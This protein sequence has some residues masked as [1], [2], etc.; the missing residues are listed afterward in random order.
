MSSALPPLDDE[1]RLP[2]RQDDAEVHPI[3]I[4]V[5]DDDVVDR[6]Q[7]RRLLGAASGFEVAAETALAAEAE[8]VADQVDLLILDH[9]LPDGDG[10]EVLARLRERGRGLPV[11]A[12]TGTRDDQ[13]AA[14]LIKAGADDYLAK[15]QLSG[16]RLCHSIRTT[17][18]A[19]RDR[20]AAERANLALADLAALAE[21]SDDLALPALVAAIAR[22]WDAQACA[23]LVED[24]EGRLL[25]RASTGAPGFAAMPIPPGIH[26]RHH[27]DRTA[28]ALRDGD[29]RARGLIAVIS[30]G[31]PH[32]N[33]LA[34]L[35]IAASRAVAV[36]ERAEQRAHLEQAW[37]LERAVAA[38]ARDLLAHGGRRDPT[39]A[40]R[41]LLEGLDGERIL[42]LAVEG[43]HLILRHQ[44]V[45]ADRSPSSW[46]TVPW[47]P[48]LTR[49]RTELEE[50][51]AVAGSL[52][53]LH[54]DEQAAFGDDVLGS[55]ALLPLHE[56]DRL[57]AVLRMDAREPRH[58]NRDRLRSLRHA[59]QLIQAWW[60]QDP[61]RTH[62]QS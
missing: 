22:A 12:L 62:V 8:T 43:E 24:D 9:L 27:G 51:A 14:A 7:V 23:C 26:P 18:Q 34:V 45:R 50:G 5:V 38:M 33:A 40:V 10:L 53:S 16:E 52:S 20:Q 49:W 1:G 19:W 48:R 39:V 55:V 31:I 54:G 44:V 47:R 28:I 46:T 56:G 15:D 11:L 3:R 13:V 25:C 32:A 17:V 29:G 30:E 58:W 59:V 57:T 41:Q 60:S 42:L 61:L 36:L 4:G 37:R 21:A 2:E 35:R 6:L